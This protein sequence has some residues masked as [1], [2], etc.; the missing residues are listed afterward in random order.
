MSSGL[1][2]I[3]FTI[4]KLIL[5]FDVIGRTYPV[6]PGNPASGWSYRSHAAAVT[7]GLRRVWSRLVRVVLVDCMPQAQESDWPHCFRQHPVN[8]LCNN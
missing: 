8:I 6:I 3:Y 4:L 7:P 2:E 1:E 5:N